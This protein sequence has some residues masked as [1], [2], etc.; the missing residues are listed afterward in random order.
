MLFH[1]FHASVSSRIGSKTKSVAKS[2]QTPRRS[3]TD[4]HAHHGPTGVGLI[5]SS[6]RSDEDVQCPICLLEM[7]DGESLTICDGCSNT[8]HQHCMA[9]C[10]CD[11]ITVLQVELDEEQWDTIT[12]NACG[13]A[14]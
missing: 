13:D 3:V 12:L 6:P 10:K 11:K 2:K 14:G 8:L 7:V 4:A 5:N 1:K 9:I